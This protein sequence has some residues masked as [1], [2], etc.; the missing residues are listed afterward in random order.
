MQLLLA[1]A[2]INS[3]TSRNAFKYLQCNNICIEFYLE[4]VSVEEKFL[5]FKMDFYDLL[6]KASLNQK[7]AEKEAS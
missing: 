7:K 4:F 3:V 6:K 1:S 2:N 5:I